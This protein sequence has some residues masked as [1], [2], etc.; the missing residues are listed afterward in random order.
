MKTKHNK[1]RNTA[2][3]FEALVKELTK[4]I[5][6]NNTQKSFHIKTILKEHFNANSVLHCELDCYRALCENANLDKYTAEKIIYRA[7]TSYDKLDKKKIFKEQSAVIKKINSRLGSDVYNNFIPDYKSYATL[8]Q[9]FGDRLPL[10]NRVLLE[11]KVMDRLMVTPKA[12]DELPHVDS[13]VLTSF[14]KRFN[15]SYKDLLPEQ[16]SL[17][18]KYM[19]SFGDNLVDFKIFLAE[20]LGRIRDSV[21]NSLIL[22]EVC[23]DEDMIENTHRLLEKIDK[24]SISS[25]D[26]GSLGKILKLQSLVNEYDKDADKN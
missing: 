24:M 26:E 14:S 12:S 11:Q 4:A 10:K 7:K 6:S 5:V 21:K 23:S 19:V 25:V 18:Q 9:I 22:E 2:F 13:L 8:F 3:L 20:E 16:K 17:L 1:K 15:E